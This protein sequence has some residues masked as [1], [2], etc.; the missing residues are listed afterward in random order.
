MIGNTA[1]IYGSYMYPNSAKPRF[2][3]GGVA[4]TII[5]LLV[6]L[7]AF[8]LRFVHIHENRK[9]E[10]A[11]RETTAEPGA[12]VDDEAEPVGRR[13]IGFRYVY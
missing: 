7:L 2:L 13:A 1:T 3:A 9:L 8:V 12:G 11:E 6:A 10:R 5:C 4:N